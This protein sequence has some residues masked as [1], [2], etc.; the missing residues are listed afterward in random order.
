MNRVLAVS[1]GWQGG[2]VALASYP[3]ALEPDIDDFNTLTLRV[4]SDGLAHPVLSCFR[5]SLACFR[6]SLFPAPERR[7][8]IVTVS[9][10]MQADFTWHSSACAPVSRRTCQSCLRPSRG[11]SL[12]RDVQEESI[13]STSKLRHCRWK[14][15][16]RYSIRS[17]K[18]SVKSIRSIRY[19]V[20][21]IRYSIR[22]ISIRSI[23]YFPCGH[24]R[25]GRNPRGMGVAGA[26]GAR[27]RVLGEFTCPGLRARATA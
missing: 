12:G 14:Q 7:P 1:L 25:V 18:C 3:H 13:A 16:I 21:S 24:P 5:L 22:S 15:S 27:G 19:Y 2:F 9:T 17:I 6:L 23:K 8:C 10:E 26:R 20:I 11:F 4:K